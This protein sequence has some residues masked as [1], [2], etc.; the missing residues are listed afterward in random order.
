MQ[1]LDVVTG[2]CPYWFGP[3]PNGEVGKVR[4]CLVMK[5]ARDRV[6][7]APGHGNPVYRDDPDA[8]VVWPG[9]PE[10]VNK[11]TTFRLGRSFWLPQSEVIRIGSLDTRRKGLVPPFAWFTENAKDV[12]A[13]A[14]AGGTLGGWKR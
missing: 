4:V 13:S 6:Y 7:V 2:F 10:A 3:K 12:F 5:V 1:Q 11:V 9:G 14:R 8:V